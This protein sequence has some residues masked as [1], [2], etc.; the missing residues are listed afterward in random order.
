M[1]VFVGQ[2]NAKESQQEDREEGCVD[3]INENVQ[4][5]KRAHW[6]CKGDV[7]AID[8]KC[9]TWCFVTQNTLT[10]E[11]TVSDNTPQG[12]NQCCQ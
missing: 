8:G 2:K 5:K 9:F 11:D 10:C 1:V 6:N 3:E 7:S 4:V 12:T